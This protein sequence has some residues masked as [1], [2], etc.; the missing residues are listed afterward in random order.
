MTHLTL[1]ANKYKS[2]KGTQFGAA[3]SFTEIYD[4]YFNSISHLTLNVLE[5]GVLDGSSLN[6]W[7][8]YFPNSYIYGVD[9]NDKSLYEND[10]ISC[11]ILDQSNES[12]LI[13]FNENFNIEFDI[14]IDDGSHH[15]LDQ[16]L[17]FGYLFPLLKSGGLYII[18]DLHTSTCRP[19]TILYNRP[20]EIYADRSNTTLHYLKNKPLNSVYLDR[21]RNDYIQNNVATI[22]IHDVA[23]NNVTDVYNRTSITSVITKK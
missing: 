12:H 2:D 9:I 22:N 23:N 13:H 19:G 20:I 6:M 14:I 11:G 4:T 18:E 16:Q 10:R 15:M 8:D 17:T 1:L 3:H 21:D 7:Y 5:I